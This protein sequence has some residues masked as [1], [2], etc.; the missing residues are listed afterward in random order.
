V[1]PVFGFGG[2][3]ID[4]EVLDTA[5]QVDVLFGDTDIF[6]SAWSVQRS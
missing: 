6:D 4:I 2:Q 3:H 5:S 1:V